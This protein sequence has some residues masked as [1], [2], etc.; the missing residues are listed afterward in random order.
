MKRGKSMVKINIING[1]GTYVKDC[2]S[3]TID[4]AIDYYGQE[5]EKIILDT[6]TN[7][8]FYEWQANQNILEVYKDI[9]E[10]VLSLEKKIYLNQKKDSIEGIFFEEEQ[11]VVYKNAL[12]KRN[13]H[14]L[15]HET[16][17][18]AVF[19]HLDRKIVINGQNYHRNGLK[20]RNANL[21]KDEYIN[22][23]FVELATNNIMKQAS[24]YNPNYNNYENTLL[25]AWILTD[26][27]GKKKIYDHLILN[28]GDIRKDFDENLDIT[29]SFYN[30]ENTSFIIDKLYNTIYIP[31]Y[32]F[33]FRRYQ[34]SLNEFIKRKKLK[35]KRG[36]F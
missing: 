13:Y 4:I 9:R 16:L 33:N 15:I 21:V 22:E 25:F 17:G 2:F 23:G 11:V 7:I 27:L 35:I 28:K 36:R 24:L 19:G 12:L 8:S 34:E 14:T 6:I 18:H 3:K 5:Y 30:W 32:P 29:D 26:I 10:S 20:L 31:E 1:D